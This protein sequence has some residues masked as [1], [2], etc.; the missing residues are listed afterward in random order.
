MI[1]TKNLIISYLS[2]V[3]LGPTILLHVPSSLP[4]LLPLGI[5]TKSGPQPPG[6]VLP[7]LALKLVDGRLENNVR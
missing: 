2:M 7:V 4:Q 5:L 1:L 6:L 3:G